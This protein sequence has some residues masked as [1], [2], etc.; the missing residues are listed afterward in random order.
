MDWTYESLLRVLNRD[1]EH[2]LSIILSRLESGSDEV[3]ITPVGAR[4]GP[5]V[6]F[7]EWDKLFKRNSNKMNDVL[8][9]IEENQR[10]KFGP[11]SIQ[12]PW[13]SISSEVLST[14]DI[15]D[16][17][18]SHLSSDPL[19]SYDKGK[20]RPLSV[21]QAAK[22]LKPNTNSGL[23]FLSKKGQVRDLT[24]ENLDELFWSNYPMVPFTRTQEQGKTRVIMG[25]PDSD[26]IYETCYFEPI[27]GY[28]S[29]QEQFAAMRGPKDV[30]TAMT[31]L[32]YEAVRLGQKCVSG[33]ISGFDRDVG[34]SLQANTFKEM[35]SLLQ[36]PNDPMFKEITYRF[37]NKGLVV[38]GQ[39]INGPHGI[40]SGSRGTNLVGSVGN[41]RVNGL[42]LRQILGDD[43]ASVTSSVSELFERYEKCGLELN[44]EKTVVADG[45]FLYLQMLFHPDYQWN[46]EIVGVYPTWRALNRLV[47]PERFSDFESYGLDGKEFFAIRSLSILEN[48]KYHP[49][50]VE[51]V[52]FWLRFEKYAIPENYSIV[53]YVQYHNATTGSIGTTNQ[54]G[55]DPRGLTSFE[56]YK[57]IVKLL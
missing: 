51:I 43:F 23:P 34:P 46:N 40:P 32:L 10:N 6:I 42:P 16:V 24:L 1:Q 11:R 26:I 37:G 44:E 21:G 50:F 4:V 49:L 30:N 14:F 20:L 29:K 17:N 56:S 47:Y 35:S 55:D 48:C 36:D 9:D 3:R 28:Y 33:D 39:V 45:Y 52:K 57:L 15:K 41:D 25:Y 8:I 7:A 27:F 5:D 31:R 22:L 13:S 38:P 54:Y 19:K 2:K 12:Q 53:K 18:C